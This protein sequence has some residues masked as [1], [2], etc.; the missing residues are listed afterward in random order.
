MLNG[1]I[2][3]WRTTLFGALS[4]LMTYVLLGDGTVFPT[5][6]QGWFAWLGGLAQAIWGAVQKDSSTGSKAV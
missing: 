6:R 2:G 4:G 5:T 3:N 1:L